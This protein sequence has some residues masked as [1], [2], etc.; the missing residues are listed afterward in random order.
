MRFFTNQSQDSNISPI[1]D[2]VYWKKVIDQYIK[3][4]IKNFKPSLKNCDGGLYVGCA[5]ISYMLYKAYTLNLFE[6]CDYLKMDFKEYA[7]ASLTYVESHKEKSI[8]EISFLLGAGGV[9]V[10]NALVKDSLGQKEASQMMCQRY[11]NLAFECKPLILSK[12]GSDELFVG[13]AGYLNGA[14]ILNKHFNTQIVKLSD[15][16]DI[17]DSVVKSG[18]DYSLKNKSSSPL[19]YAYYNTEYLGAAHGLSGILLMLLE[20]PDYLSLRPESAQLIIGSI[21]WMG[22]VQDQFGGN[23]PPDVEE[24]FHRRPVPEE[25]VHWCHGGPGAIYLFA[26]AYLIFKDP[27]YLK[28]CRDIGDVVWQRGL[29]KKGPGICHGIAGNGYVFLLLFKITG[30]QIYF[31]RALQ[32]ANFLQTEEFRSG[33]R[34]PDCPYSLYEGIAGTVCF[35]LDLIKPQMSNFPFLDFY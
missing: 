11:S 29:L 8:P 27:K 34:T 6:S 28:W 4:I 31:N 23:L 15:L 14:L 12:N 22:E 35:L 32:F 7:E 20:V 9:Y 1:I 21:N 18:R 26:K 30:E 17:C 2:E 33:T 16:Y 5:G 13:R 24:I 19:M 3:S 25:L 10:L